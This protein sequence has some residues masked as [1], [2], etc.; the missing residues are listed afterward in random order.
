MRPLLE[1]SSKAT[2]V[3]K[4]NFTKAREI[5]SLVSTNLGLIGE[6]T[7]SSSPMA[8][9]WLCQKK[10]PFFAM[11]CTSDVKRHIDGNVVELVHFES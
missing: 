3:P 9:H 1:F 5:P 4:N 6:E 2:V 8:D 10:L 7:S 11:A